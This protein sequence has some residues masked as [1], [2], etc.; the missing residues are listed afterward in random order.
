MGDLITRGCGGFFSY[1]AC[2]EA[3]THTGCVDVHS[4]SHTYRLDL[5]PQ[6]TLPL[7]EEKRSLS[8][9]T[10]SFETPSV[11]RTLRHYTALPPPLSSPPAVFVAH[12]IH[13]RF[14]FLSCWVFFFYAPLRNLDCG[15]EF[16]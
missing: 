11:D 6:H 10:V 2:D 12:I 4:T 15:P 13:L 8:Q 14:D 16:K 5:T 3:E 1:R 9:T 7:I